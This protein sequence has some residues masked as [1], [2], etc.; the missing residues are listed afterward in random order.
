MTTEL[1]TLEKEGW[2]RRFTASEPRLSEAVENYRNLG[3][4]VLLVPV[5]ELCKA[6]EKTNCTTCFE[7]DDDPDRYKV[8]FTRPVA[9]GDGGDELF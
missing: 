7:G 6:E 5:L 8:I 2:T 3:M 1:K 9:G 4:E